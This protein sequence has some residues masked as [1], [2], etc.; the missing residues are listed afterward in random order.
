MPCATC[1]TQCR[2]LE[3]SREAGLFESKWKSEDSLRVFFGG[4]QQVLRVSG[5][6]LASLNEIWL[7]VEDGNRTRRDGFVFGPLSISYISLS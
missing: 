6:I 4:L 5:M 1:R 2:S 3:A 7:S